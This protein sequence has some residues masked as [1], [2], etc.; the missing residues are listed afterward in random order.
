MKTIENR[1][2]KTLVLVVSLILSFSVFGQNADAVDLRLAKRVG[3]NFIKMNPDIKLSV[4][5]FV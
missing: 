3:E 5:T 4:C 1:I 2:A